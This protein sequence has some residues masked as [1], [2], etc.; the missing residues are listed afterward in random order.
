MTKELLLAF[1]LIAAI[2]LLPVAVDAQGVPQTIA[3]DKADLRA[4]SAGYRGSK[5][6][7]ASVSNR[8]DIQKNIRKSGYQ[9]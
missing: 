5:L 3:G 2:P 7:G 9:N 1:G 8:A 6:V 4:V